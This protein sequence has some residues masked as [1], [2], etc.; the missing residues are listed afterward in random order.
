MAMSKAGLSSVLY[1]VF[2]DAFGPFRKKVRRDIEPFCDAL[3]DA[4]VTY[5]TENAEVR[6]TTSTTGLQ[7]VDDPDGLPGG[8]KD[9]YAP[10]STKTLNIT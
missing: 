1:D 10:T 4:L 8:K 9:T 5:I 6:I 2:E 3:A 7:Q